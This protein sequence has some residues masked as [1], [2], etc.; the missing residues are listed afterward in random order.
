MMLKENYNKEST[1]LEKQLELNLQLL[2]VLNKQLLKDGR[3]SKKVLKMCIIK[4]LRK[5]V[6]LLE[7][8]PKAKLNKLNKISKKVQKIPKKALKKQFNQKSH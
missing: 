4:L 1:R 6:K 3:V 5:S 2:K 8:M 7:L